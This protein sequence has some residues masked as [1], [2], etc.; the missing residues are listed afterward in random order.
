MHG[1][2]I[3]AFPYVSP[4]VTS[5]L[6]S[7]HLDGGN[8][9]EHH[10]DLLSSGDGYNRRF[11]A[12]LSSFERKERCVDNTIHYDQILTHTAAAYNM[13]V[14]KT[15]TAAT[16][17]DDLLQESTSTIMVHHVKIFLIDEIQNF[18]QLQG[19]QMNFYL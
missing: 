16:V 15:H 17:E 3:I 1:T 4:I 18:I 14:T 9:Q 7:P 19:S 8:I 2:A 11:D 12:I 5:P 10:K 6:S 13:S